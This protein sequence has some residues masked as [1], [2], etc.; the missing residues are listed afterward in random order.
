MLALLDTADGKLA[1]LKE[2]AI[3]FAQQTNDGRLKK[4]DAV[5]EL[6][7]ISELIDDVGREEIEKIVGEAFNGGTSRAIGRTPAAYS[8]AG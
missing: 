5:D 2:A 3:D 8:I 4:T 6:I 7:K 1:A